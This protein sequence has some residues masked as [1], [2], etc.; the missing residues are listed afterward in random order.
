LV[1]NEVFA[2]LGVPRSLSGFLDEYLFLFDKSDF[3]IDKYLFIQ[4]T[5]LYLPLN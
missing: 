5:D 3:F 2:P 1:E 4:K